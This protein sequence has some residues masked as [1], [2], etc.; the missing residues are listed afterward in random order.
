VGQR[1]LGVR[2]RRLDFARWELGYDSAPMVKQVRWHF[3]PEPRT[4]LELE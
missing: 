2:R 3:A 1:M 4:E